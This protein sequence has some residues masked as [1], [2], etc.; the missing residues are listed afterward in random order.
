MS[1]CAPMMDPHRRAALWYRLKITVQV[2]LF[3]GA[4][5]LGALS[6]RV[7]QQRAARDPDAARREL[8]SAQQQAEI[9][10]GAALLSPTWENHAALLR[11]LCIAREAG[12]T[13][14]YNRGEWITEEHLRPTPEQMALLEV[15]RV[16]PSAEQH[17]LEWQE[18]YRR[19]AERPRSLL[20]R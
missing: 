13:V 1:D 8:L 18:L 17:E 10:R 7:W 5:L 20:E 3:L 16:S 9:A 11:R 6:H 12:W 15:L 19:V 2:G 14:R 4:Y